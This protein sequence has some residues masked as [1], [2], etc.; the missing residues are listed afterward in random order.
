METG[1]KTE[2]AEKTTIPNSHQ[3]NFPENSRRN[4]TALIS[5]K[6]DTEKRRKNSEPLQPVDHLRGTV[7][8]HIQSH[9][10][11]NILSARKSEKICLRMNLPRNQNNATEPNKAVEPTPVAVTNRACPPFGRARFAPSTRMAHL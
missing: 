7:E 5:L 4:S 9:Q 8:R 6:A 11:E 2:L 1:Q 3:P 10:P